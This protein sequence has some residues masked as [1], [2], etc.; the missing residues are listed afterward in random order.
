MLF[1]RPESVPVNA[2][3]AALTNLQRAFLQGIYDYFH[4]HGTWPMFA[5]IDRPPR[6]EHGAEPGLET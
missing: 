3:V 4:E 1:R 5:A 6:R 2:E